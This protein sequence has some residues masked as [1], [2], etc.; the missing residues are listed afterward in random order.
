MN[1]TPPLKVPFWPLMISVASPFPGH[2]QT[3][4]NG[5]ATQLV[6][7]AKTGSDAPNAA[8][9][10][11]ARPTPNLLSAARRMTDRARLLARSSNLLFMFSFR[12]G[13]LLADTAF[14]MLAHFP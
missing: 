12:F 5:G 1:E 3:S 11:P 10:M 9:A 2:Q 13:L 8:S 6:L 4:P 14:K 7:C